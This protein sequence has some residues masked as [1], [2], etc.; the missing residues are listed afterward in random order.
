VGLVSRAA[1]VAWLPGA[2]WSR[3]V[4]ARESLEPAAGRFVAYAPVPDGR[5]AARRFLEDARLPV[6]TRLG[7]CADPWCLRLRFPSPDGDLVALARG[8]GPRRRRRR[9]RG[10]DPGSLRARCAEALRDSPPGTVEVA[11][12]TA[13]VA[14]RSALVERVVTVDPEGIEVT[15]RGAV[16]RT[17][18]N[19][20]EELAVLLGRELGWDPGR[21]AVLPHRRDR[22]PPE[23]PG[24]PPT[25]V[26]RYLWEDLELAAADQRRLLLAAAQVAQGARDPATIDLERLGPLHDVVRRWSEAVAGASGPARARRA[27]ALRQLLERAREA[28]PEDP[29]IAAALVRRLLEGPDDD[30]EAAFAIV[31]DVLSSRVASPEPWRR[32]RR[33]VAAARDLAGPPDAPAEHLARWLAADGLVREGPPAREAAASILAWRRAGVAHRLAEEAWAVEGA[34]GG[35]GRLRPVPPLDVPLGDVPVLVGWLV[36]AALLAHGGSGD[37][38]SGD[39]DP[40]LALVVWAE[41]PGLR[42]ARRSP[43]RATGD[44]ARRRGSLRDDDRGGGDDDDPEVL[45]G[46]LPSGA[47]GGRFVGIGRLPAPGQE[48]PGDAPIRKLGARLARQ[49]GVGAVRLSFGVRRLDGPAAPDPVLTLAGRVDDLGAFDVDA[50]DAPARRLPWRWLDDEVVPAIATLER[51]FPEPE[52]VLSAPRS[53]RERARRL[54]GIVCRPRE[55]ELRCVSDDRTIGPRSLEI[56]VV[57]AVAEALPRVWFSRLTVR[58][59]PSSRRGSPSE[60]R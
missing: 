49:S 50:V 47:S 34:L 56:F 23:T 26:E 38:A 48:S 21:I 27:R 36:R 11:V 10:D 14:G 58:L 9:L 25:V 1:E 43:A 57:A 54:P 45:A 17:R 2:P 24:G 3:W 37:A 60:R 19:A 35:A 4:E 28:H 13:D 30:P 46:G 6:G 55:D 39:G 31:E 51:I 29:T 12:G 42:S 22:F 18:P 7:D 44:P 32:L 8:G 40:A 20:A 53:L 5:D 52:V 15:E 33:E 41:G 59:R 16:E